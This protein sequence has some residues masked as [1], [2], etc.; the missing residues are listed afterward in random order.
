MPEQ[1]RSGRGKPPLTY[2]KQTA[3]LLSTNVGTRLNP[4]TKAWTLLDV[5]LTLC[6]EF[7]VVSQVFPTC[8]SDHALVI[9]IF[10]YKPA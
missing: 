3:A 1:G 6:I 5:I 9:S 8:F 10:K 7:F 4:I 2:L